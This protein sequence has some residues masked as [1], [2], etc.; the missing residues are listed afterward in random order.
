MAYAFGLG[1][2]MPLMTIA[3]LDL[4]PRMRGLA[5]S[6]ITFV[7]M[8]VFYLMSGVIAPLAFRSAARLATVE[9]PASCCRSG[10]GHSPPPRRRK[11]PPE[12][13]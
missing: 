8:L 10:A 13:T 11:R 12:R 1:L 7:Q 3:T 6:L 5:A 9:L 4:Y 2:A